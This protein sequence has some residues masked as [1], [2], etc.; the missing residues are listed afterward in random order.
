MYR[1]ISKNQCLW[2]PSKM[3][4]EGTE[5]IWLHPLTRLSRMMRGTCGGNT[6][7]Q[8]LQKGPT[9][10][11]GDHPPSN[12]VSKKIRVR[13]QKCGT[14]THFKTLDWRSIPVQHWPR[15]S[16]LVFISSIRS[17]NGKI[18]QLK[19]NKKIHEIHKW[20][21]KP[22]LKTVQYSGYVNPSHLWYLIRIR[23]P[24]P[25]SRYSWITDPEPTV[26][27]CNWLSW[28]QKNKFYSSFFSYR[29]TY[30]RYHTYLS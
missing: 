24:L 15:K 26:L 10:T 11:N 16:F 20:T 6:D 27:F 3:P 21:P 8:H 9:G 14:I 28:C 22:I 2:K 13:W 4:T 25:G 18:D 5:M 30:R 7:Q 29:V 1:L 19:S 17:F 12:Q 23:G